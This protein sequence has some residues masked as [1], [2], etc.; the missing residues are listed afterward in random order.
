MLLYLIYYYTY[1]IIYYIL[2]YTLLFCSL[3]SYTLLL[4]SSQYL[5][6]FFLPFLLFSSSDLSS[7]L[8]SFPLPNPSLPLL[9]SPLLF[10]SSLLLFL[11]PLLLLLSSPLLLLPLFLPNIHSIR[12]GTYIRL[13][14]FYQYLILIP[15]RWGIHIYLPSFTIILFP[16]SSIF[17][18][19]FPNIHSIRV[20]SYLRLFIFQTHPKLTP[21]VLSEWMVEVGCV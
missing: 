6:L 2:Y 17:C 18:S 8:Y 9:S 1:T 11:F 13:F 20:G 7:V 14:I 4:F 19:P 15:F 21:H 12:V 10:H 5:L 16:S 3:L